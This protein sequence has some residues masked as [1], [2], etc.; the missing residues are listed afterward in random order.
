LR[1]SAC[2]RP[3]QH[4]YDVITAGYGAM[5][6]YADRV[7]PADRWAIAAYIRALQLSQHADLAALGPEL[8]DKLR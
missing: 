7:G 4:F 1:S 3:T 8:R 5:F 2:G 6:S